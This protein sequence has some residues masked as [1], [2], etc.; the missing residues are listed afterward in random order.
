MLSGREPTRAQAATPQQAARREAARQALVR[1]VLVLYGL[2]LCEGALRK[3]LL[4]EFSQALFFIRD[5]VL[6]LVYGLAFR[7]RLWPQRSSW[8]MLAWAMATFGG[9]LVLLQAAVGG[10]S[11]NRWLLG[12]YGWRSYFFYIPLAF[13]IGAQFNS[14]DIWRF[15]RITLWLSLPVAVLVVLQFYAPID[16]AI[17]VGSAADAALQFR[18]TGQ[19][20][21]RTRPMGPFASGAGQQ[22]FVAAAVALLLAAL[23][24]PP[25]RR[26]VGK[27]LMLLSALALMA[28][29][30]FSGSRG[31]VLQ[32][33]LAA[34]FALA[35]LPLGRG[36][37]LRSRALLWPVLLG[38][39]ALL[40]APVVFPEGV[41]AFVERWSAA[42]R[43][44]SEFAGGIFGRA[45]FGL[46]DFMRLLPVVPPLGYGLGFGGNASLT[47]Q[48]T[49]DG[50]RPGLLV[51]TDF[52][53]HMVDL[54]PALGLGFIAFRLAL[55]LWLAA[56]VLRASRHGHQAMPMLLLS[57]AGYVLLLGQ[58]TGQGTINAYGWLFT[59]LCIAACRNAVPLAARA[60]GA[61]AS[62]RWKQGPRK[63]WASSRLPT[64]GFG[65]G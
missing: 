54:G 15:C 12:A 62:G 63:P 43:V 44:E 61:G 41:A 5:P 10:E 3:W 2:V 31:T 6:L 19:T 18:G 35:L 32:C 1:C 17:N 59:G 64:R 45:L 40:A 51:E 57:Y 36:M 16:A 33:A 34:A 42:S 14:P 7:H 55:V 52:A 23:V 24:T 47:L 49:V 13:L 26:R 28:C 53:R 39:L 27:A 38:A 25:A 9:L 29:L 21:E 20:A 50:V 22:Q 65:A 37:A 56:Q 8:L 4:P 60:N 30:A 46:V 48:A 58:I 11:D